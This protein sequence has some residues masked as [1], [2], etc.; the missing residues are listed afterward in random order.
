MHHLIFFSTRIS[1]ILTPLLDRTIGVKK[2]TTLVPRS[3][4]DDYSHFEKVLVSHQ[5]KVDAHFIDDELDYRQFSSFLDS[6]NIQPDAVNASCDLDFYSAALTN[7]YAGGDYPVYVV[8]FKD[9]LKW[10]STLQKYSEIEDRLKVGWFL[11]AH[12][13]TLIRKEPEYKKDFREEFYQLI[14]GHMFNLDRFLSEVAELSSSASYLRWT[15]ELSEEFNNVLS[16][17]EKHSFIDLRPESEFKIN[18]KVYFKNKKVIRF[19]K[20]E[21][22]EYFVYD[23]V[24]Q[25]QKRGNNQIQDVC[26]GSVIEKDI[27]GASIKNEMDVVVLSNNKLIL[28]ECKTVPYVKNKSGKHIRPLDFIYK[29]SAIKNRVSDKRTSGAL[30]SLHSIDSLQRSRARELGIEIFDGEI[31]V[32]QIRRKFEE[33]LNEN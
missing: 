23:Q 24:R 31:G 5:L 21:W 25:V 9:R 17:L 10:I 16:L 30:V 2:V 15:L 33:M 13:L 4:K 28:I 18:N 20:S 8:D 27:D 3:L 32:Q 14:F 1:P 19:L 26:I 6:I 11:K 7:Y 12:G 29:L 22:L